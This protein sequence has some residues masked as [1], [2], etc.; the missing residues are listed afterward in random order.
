MRRSK[1]T[2]LYPLFFIV[3]LLFIFGLS[4]RTFAAT[5]YI[6]ATTG[7]D[8]NDGLSQSTP[9]KTVLKV[10][11]SIFQPGDYLLFKRG[12]I[13]REQLLVSSSGS[14]GSPITF[15][16]Y[17]S[18]N[19]PKITSTQVISGVTDYLDVYRES[20]NKNADFENWS[21]SYPDSWGGNRASKETSFVYNGKNSVK[22]YK[23]NNNLV[24]LYGAF[25]YIPGA[26]YVVKFYAKGA[27]GGEKILINKEHYSGGIKQ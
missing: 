20:T 2:L 13:W 23:D 15:G 18:G 25:N 3:S 26:R 4:S 24:N 14:P 9:W 17:G 21:G 5:Y 27:S 6:D 11:N 12:E 22:L 19:L 16:A 8:S 10:N 1:I 7:N